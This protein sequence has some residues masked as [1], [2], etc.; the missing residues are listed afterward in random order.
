MKRDFL[1]I[2]IVICGL[3]HTNI[4][5]G[6]SLYLSYIDTADVNIR[7]KNWL[8]AERYL[9]MALK[10][11]P[12][13]SNNSLLIS[14]LATVQRYQKKY[15][16]ALKNYDVALSM[17]PKAVTLLK[18]RA[19][20]YL[21]LD[22]LSHAYMDYEKVILLDKE[23]LESR[24]YHGL[25]ALRKGQMDVAKADVADLQQINRYS[26]YTLEAKGTLKKTL[27]DFD[28]AIECYTDLI[29][30]QAKPSYQTLIN[31]AECYLE[32]KRLGD[33]ENDIKRALAMEPTEAYIYVLRARL[34]KL[35]YNERDKERDLQLAEKYGISRKM[36]LFFMK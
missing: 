1:L 12:A 22:S 9:L 18:N 20:L 5:K 7:A 34:N 10:Q 11:E 31:R 13:N 27:G 23:D 4:V 15:A 28:E 30:M 29:K 3:F 17:T 6:Q 36:A 24:Y 32:V 21:E 19:S 16:E 2:L 25:I 33:A 8:Q 26:P 35:R 14:N